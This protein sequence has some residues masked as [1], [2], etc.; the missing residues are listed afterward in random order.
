MKME[1]VGAI[2]A[3]VAAAIITAKATVSA[4][5]A[6]TVEMLQEGRSKSLRSGYLHAH[7]LLQHSMAKGRRMAVT[8]VVEVMEL[9]AAAEVVTKNVVHSLDSSS[10]SSS[11]GRRVAWG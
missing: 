8:V 2:S 5:A 1:A 11:D 10:S 6:T 4:A 9:E 3:G 7:F